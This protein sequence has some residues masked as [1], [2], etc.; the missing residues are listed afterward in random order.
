MFYPKQILDLKLMRTL[1]NYIFYI[2]I[3][4]GGITSQL[5][6]QPSVQN[7]G[8]TPLDRDGFGFES[9]IHQSILALKMAES[10]LKD[11]ITANKLV[12]IGYLAIAQ[13]GFSTTTK[14]INQRAGYWM[15]PYPIAIKY[16]LTINKVIDER[17]NLSKSTCAAYSYWQYLVKFYKNEEIADFVFTESAIAI[18]KFEA[19]S[20][21]NTFGGN[22]L[23]SR[24][25]RLKKIKSI[26]L[27]A[28]IKAVGPE[29]SVVTVTS[30]Q[31]ISFKAIH[32]FIQIPTV[33]LVKLN[34]EW[35]AN[36]YNP[37]L[38]SLTLPIK[39]QEA[40]T[41]ATLAMEQKTKDDKVLHLAA[42]TKRIKLLKGNIPNLNSHKPVRYK[43]KAGDNL[44]RIAQR[45]HVKISSIRAW[46]ELRSDRIYAGKKLTIYVPINQ[47]IEKVE[48]AKKTP[49]K[50]KKANL[51]TGEY[52]EYTV[53][54]GD[55]LWAISQLFEYITADM[56][57]EDNSIDENIAPGQVLKIREIE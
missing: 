30:N 9:E 12:Q 45:Y 47:K 10:T 57:M 5:V 37:T 24:K 4:V 48:A 34:P 21:I 3:G 36:L 25:A 20:I 55:T 15:L 1:I 40:F 32:H 38:G 16:G 54:T 6:A 2:S 33:E 44:G 43:V 31:P 27:K 11:S 17:K 41:Q 18:V 22:S 53:K 49:K 8:F 19:D 50:V 14:D 13:S 39:Y 23:V 29:A 35:V 46:N 52:Q 28:N 56:I 51:K 26:Y 42:N 7:N